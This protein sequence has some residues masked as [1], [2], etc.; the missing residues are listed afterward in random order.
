MA[1]GLIFSNL[2]GIYMAFK[3]SRS[4]ALV[5]GLLLL[6]TAIPGVLLVMMA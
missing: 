5:W 2:L 6:G 1:V 3:Y 4:R